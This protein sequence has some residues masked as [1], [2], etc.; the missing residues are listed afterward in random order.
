[1]ACC[2]VFVGAAAVGATGYV[3]YVGATK[4]R[5]VFKKSL[6]KRREKK[7]ARKAEAKAILEKNVATEIQGE[8]VSGTPVTEPNIP[9]AAAE[10]PLIAA[11][12]DG[13]GCS[14]KKLPVATTV[15]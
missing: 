8:V 3:G 14:K 9:V 6:Q 1:M 4:L 10:T 5:R 13:C 2:V 12:A 11:P 7:E 15:G